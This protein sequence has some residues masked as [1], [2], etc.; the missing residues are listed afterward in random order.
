MLINAPA[1][2]L[3]ADFP[4]V[5]TRC[6][7][8]KS[9]LR[10]GDRVTA[11]AVRYAGDDEWVVPRLYCRDCLSTITEPTL[12]A[13]ELLVTGRL[14]C[15]MDTATQQSSLTLLGIERITKSASGEGYATL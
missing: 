9:T 2:Q 11:Y 5:E 12:G 7:Y 3:F 14:G 8:C 15:L 13:T 1:E 10:E 4:T 6:Q